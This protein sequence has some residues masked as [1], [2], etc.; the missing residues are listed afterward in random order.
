M[1]NLTTFNQQ[2]YR[3]VAVAPGALTTGDY[4]ATF[5]DVAQ[6]ERFAF[7]IDLGAVGA[8]SIDMKVV[9]AT[10]AAGTGKK[11]VTGAA[12][13]QLD[14]DDDNKSALIEVAVNKL[15]INNGFRYVAVTLTRSGGSSNTGAITF[16]GVNP[17]VA[18]VTQ[19]AALLES[20]AV[21]A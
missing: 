9:Q 18:P 17:D 8:T 11:D 16:Y 6:F 10:A 21:L 19:P 7:V 14:G 13:T 5:I 3:Q 15:D 12:I 4:P 1:G 2:V 20:V